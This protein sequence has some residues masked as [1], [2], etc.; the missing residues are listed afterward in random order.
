[1]ITNIKRHFF[2]GLFTGIGAA[3]VLHLTKA[4][5]CVYALA[6]G[7][8]AITVLFEYAQMLFSGKK[9]KDYLKDGKWLD[10]IVDIAAGNA[11]YWII[12]VVSIFGTYQGNVL[13]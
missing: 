11:G 13:R 1:M 4:E 2:T 6:L 7:W 8:F 9:A 3:I 10:C 12:M 5:S